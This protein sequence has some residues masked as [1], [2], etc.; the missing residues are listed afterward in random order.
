GE[1]IDWAVKM[2]RLPADAT[3][4]R[5]LE[6]GEVAAAAAEALAARVASFH[7]AAE[8]GPH[9]SAFGRFDVVAGNARENFA[10]AAPHVGTLVGPGVFGRLR[11]LNEQA[12][13]RL[14]PLMEA[15]AARGVP[16]D[17]H[18]DLHLDH[19]YLFPERP[20]P[21][22]LVVIDCIEFNERFRFA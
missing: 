14:R 7:A 1:V 5:R 20:P 21:G 13:A 8:A 12:L 6:R 19:V 15:R 10:Q 17:T 3:L 9:V 2:Q 11:E 16:R 4:E 18:G 22:D